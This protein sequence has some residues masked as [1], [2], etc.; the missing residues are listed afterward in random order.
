MRGAGYEVVPEA[1]V[2]E[3]SVL[4]DGRRPDA[5]PLHG[6]KYGGRCLVPRGAVP[7]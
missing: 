6:K 3:H 7:A 5:I 4:G 2:L 1:E